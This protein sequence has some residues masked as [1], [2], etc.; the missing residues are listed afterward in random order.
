MGGWIHNEWHDCDIFEDEG[1]KRRNQIRLL[2][3]ELKV[4]KKESTNSLTIKETS[5]QENCVIK[6]ESTNSLTIKET[7][8]QENC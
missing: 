5:F 2:L 8:F 7:I 4:I 6:K 3:E 1:E